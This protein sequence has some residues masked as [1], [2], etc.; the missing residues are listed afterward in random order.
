MNWNKQIQDGYIWRSRL[1]KHSGNIIVTKSDLS[2]DRKSERKVKSRHIEI[3]AHK[4]IS[5]CFPTKDLFWYFREFRRG[6][7]LC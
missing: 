3:S 5:L 2:D 1:H 4:L 6:E 7:I